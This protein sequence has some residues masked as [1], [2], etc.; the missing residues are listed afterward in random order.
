MGEKRRE[1]RN[2]EFRL[3]IWRILHILRGALR[4]VRRLANQLIFMVL[5]VA[6]LTAGYSLHCIDSQ[7]TRLG[8]IFINNPN[9]IMYIVK[10]EILQTENIA[11]KRFE[12]PT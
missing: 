4:K 10:A 6:M 8:M 3:K 9:Q 5:L 1:D 12:V 7:I 2:D 11:L